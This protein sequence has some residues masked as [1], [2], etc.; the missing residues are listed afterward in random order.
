MRLSSTQPAPLR[1]GA[2]VLNNEGPGDSINEQL[3][4][5]KKVADLDAAELLRPS[6]SSPALPKVGLW[7]L[8][9]VD[10]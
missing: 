4:A 3:A 7:T 1:L 6:S 5:Q 10:P 9:Q 2:E 8:N